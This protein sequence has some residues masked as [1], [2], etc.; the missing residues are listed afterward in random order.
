M[1]SGHNTDLLHNGV[2]YHVQ[3]EDKGRSNPV[4]ESFIYIGG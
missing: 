3:T 2:V 1:I 4:I